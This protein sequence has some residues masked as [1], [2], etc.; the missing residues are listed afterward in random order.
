MIN[1][2]RTATWTNMHNPRVRSP[3]DLGDFLCTWKWHGFSSQ[4]PVT[5]ILQ[6]WLGTKKLGPSIGSMGSSQVRTFHYRCRQRR[7][8]GCRA[9]SQCALVWLGW[10]NDEVTPPRITLNT[11]HDWTPNISFFVRQWQK[12]RL[13]LLLANPIPLKIPITEPKNLST[14]DERIWFWS[15]VSSQVSATSK[16]LC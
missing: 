16:Y 11:S 12:R 13:R 3:E 4:D 8:A 7:R 5:I 9:G 10:G 1:L 2:T 6:C 14:Q 15:R